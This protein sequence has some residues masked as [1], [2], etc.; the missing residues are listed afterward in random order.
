MKPKLERELK[1]YEWVKDKDLSKFIAS[2]HGVTNVNLDKQK[3]STIISNIEHSKSTSLVNPWSVKTAKSGFDSISESSQGL[4][5]RR[6]KKKRKKKL[7]STNRAII[8]NF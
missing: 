6:K 3:L 1:F 2:F 8:F 7:N 4:S 5:I